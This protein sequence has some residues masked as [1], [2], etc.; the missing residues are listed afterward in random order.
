MYSKKTGHIPL[1]IRERSDITFSRGFMRDVLALSA[2]AVVERKTGP[3]EFIAI[4]IIEICFCSSSRL[5]R[6]N[7][8]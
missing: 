4:G 8:Q 1:Q 7:G 3:P 5:C 6:N 2:L